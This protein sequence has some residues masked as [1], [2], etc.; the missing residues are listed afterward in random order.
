MSICIHE[1]GL[2]PRKYKQETSGTIPSTS[3]SLPYEDVAMAATRSRSS[4]VVFIAFIAIVS[5]RAGE[6]RVCI[7]LCRKNMSWSTT[8][9]ELQMGVLTDVIDTCHHALVNQTWLATNGGLP[10]RVR[11]VSPRRVVK[12]H[13]QL[14]FRA[15][16]SMTHFYKCGFL[17]LS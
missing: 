4:A 14:A 9:G 17:T 2:F 7:L 5:G 8:R 15:Y 11:H 13:K 3:L 16:R 1:V 6:V 12:V 10:Q